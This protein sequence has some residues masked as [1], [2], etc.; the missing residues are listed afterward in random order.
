MGRAVACRQ[1][2]D[3]MSGLKDPASRHSTQ[4]SCED[5]NTASNKCPRCQNGNHSGVS[6]I[7]VVR[8]DSIEL[9][10]VLDKIKEN[11]DS[12][13]VAQLATECNLQEN[14]S[15]AKLLIVNTLIATSNTLVAVAKDLAVK[16][17]VR[18]AESKVL[19]DE[20]DA[21]IAEVEDLA[22]GDPAAAIEK[23]ANFARSLE[24]RFNEPSEF[25]G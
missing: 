9:A 1:S 18:L 22:T 19:V 12:I 5:T 15:A 7:D 11:S 23:L 3:I 6:P 16:C 25:D 24:K 17:V 4:S 14:K 8:A 20:K 13:K 2:S 21:I 10:C